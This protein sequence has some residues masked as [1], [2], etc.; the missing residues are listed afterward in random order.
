MP[1]R[2]SVRTHYLVPHWTDFGG[3]LTLKAFMEIC[4]KNSC[5][6]YVHA[7]VHRDVHVTVRLEVHVTVHRD[8]HVTVRRD[9][10]L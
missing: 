8:V 1:V 5:F 9:R 4:P 10:S 7:T 2:P 6:F 3:V